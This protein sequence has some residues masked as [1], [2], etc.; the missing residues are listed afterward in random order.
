MWTIQQALRT[1]PPLCATSIWKDVAYIKNM[2]ALIRTCIKC[3]EAT[4][5]YTKKSGATQQEQWPSKNLLAR[6][7]INSGLTITFD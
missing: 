3:F 5:S 2:P 7:L 4:K 1:N 6:L